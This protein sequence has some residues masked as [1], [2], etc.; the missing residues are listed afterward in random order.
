MDVRLRAYRTQDFTFARGLYFETMRWAI[1]RLFGWDEA[2]QEESFAGWFKPD[3]V[4]IVMADGA[5]VGWIQQRLDRDAIF[6][7]SIYRDANDAREGH[8]H[9]R[10]PD[11]YRSGKK[12]V[13]GGNLG[14]YEDQSG[15]RPL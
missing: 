2:H 10:H 1:E 6:L 11:A 15:C 12:A 14:R 9:A 8:R 4:S 3:E 7:G 5:D 13:P